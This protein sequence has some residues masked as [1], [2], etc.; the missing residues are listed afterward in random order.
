MHNA[1]APAAAAT[2][3][4]NALATLHANGYA[5]DR[6]T[7]YNMRHTARRTAYNLRKLRSAGRKYYANKAIATVVAHSM[8]Q[9]KAAQRYGLNW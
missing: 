1:L 4:L 2:N 7:A 3:A 8:A 5:I 9:F 6:A